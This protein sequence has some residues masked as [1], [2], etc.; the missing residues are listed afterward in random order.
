[1]SASRNTS[2]LIFSLMLTPLGTGG[3]MINPAATSFILN[4]NGAK[5]GSEDGAIHAIV[6]QL[7]ANVQQVQYN[8]AGGYINPTGIPTY[9]IGP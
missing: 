4:Q 6:S 1:M 7:E 5:G 3:A 9:N 2:I 8:S